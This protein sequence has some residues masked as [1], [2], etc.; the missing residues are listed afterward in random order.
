MHIISDVHVA[1]ICAIVA[2]TN[3]YPH[4]PIG[5]VWIYRLLFVCNFVCLFVFVCVCTVTDFSAEDKASGVKFFS[6]VHQ[7]PRKEITYFV[8][9]APPEAYRRDVPT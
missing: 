8:N 1:Y 3:Y 5:K 7:R 9:F 4:M 6:A 2:L